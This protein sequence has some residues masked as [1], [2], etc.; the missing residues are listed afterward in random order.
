MTQGTTPTAWLA[1]VISC[2]ALLATLASEVSD[3]RP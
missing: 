1:A 2:G 3:A